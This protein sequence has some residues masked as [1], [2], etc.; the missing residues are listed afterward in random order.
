MR[1]NPRTLLALAA[2]G[3]AVML[4]MS[5][6]FG[7]P[8]GSDNS[9]D[10]TGANSS[11]SAA[12]AASLAPCQTSAPELYIYLSGDKT[13][14]AKAGSPASL[15]DPVCVAN[16]ALASVKAKAGAT[17]APEYV[18]F[19]QELQNGHW[20]VLAVGAAGLCAGKLPDNV[21]KVLPGCD[22]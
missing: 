15:G 11:P 21:A 12:A 10:G 13:N 5:A 1:T 2:T 4:S 20:N 17:A 7:A 14:F 19:S 18:L 9:N 8:S 22:A 3:T 16:Y 6:C